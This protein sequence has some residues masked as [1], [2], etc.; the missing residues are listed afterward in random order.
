MHKINKDAI[1]NNI[2][3]SILRYIG[4]NPPAQ[5]NQYTDTQ[6]AIIADVIAVTTDKQFTIE[7]Y[8]FVEKEL[9]TYI[10][11][12]SRTEENYHEDYKQDSRNT[13]QIE[14]YEISELSSKLLEYSDIKIKEILKNKYN[15]VDD[16]II[17]DYVQLFDESSDLLVYGLP[18]I[19]EIEMALSEL[20]D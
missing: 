11:T 4:D 3:S 10:E 8:E 17:D 12:F 7:L 20:I 2:H 13:I 9:D 14:H 16:I 18:L 5:N 15:I 6:K 19:N 1:I